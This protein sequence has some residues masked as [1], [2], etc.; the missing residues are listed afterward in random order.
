[1]SSHPVTVINSFELP[2]GKVDDYVEQWKEI[3]RLMSKMPGFLD[4]KLH[5]ALSSETRFQLVHVA[6]WETPAAMAAAMAAPDVAALISAQRARFQVT[7]NP[8]AYETIAE[9]R[10]AS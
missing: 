7:P 9:Y 10:P 1:M 3:A 4:T 2:I 5:R 8:G 6:H